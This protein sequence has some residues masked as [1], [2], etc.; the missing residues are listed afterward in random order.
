MKGRHQQDWSWI[1]FR[2]SP[3]GGSSCELCSQVFATANASNHKYH[4]KSSHNIT[5]ESECVQKVLSPGKKQT[6]LQF[7]PSQF[8][9]EE[10]EV[11]AAAET[12]AFAE[13]CE[14]DSVRPMVGEGSTFVSE[15]LM[16]CLFSFADRAKRGDS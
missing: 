14:F 16:H 4:L 13:L 15:A 5:F 8:S 7:E 2:K 3:S 10:L 6:L 9:K 12:A 11:L 1:Y